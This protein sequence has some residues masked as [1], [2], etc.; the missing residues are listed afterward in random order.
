MRKVLI[1]AYYFPPSG[2]PGVQRV[3][4]YVQYLRDFGWEPVVLTVANG[5]FP[6]RDESLLAEIPE[7][8]E[9]IRT[10]IF[11][12]YDLYRKL[13]GKARG[14]AIDV[15]TMHKE[16]AKLP[17]KERI[18]ELI[19]ATIF[20]PDA[21]IGWY[22]TAV[23]AGLDAIEREGIEAIYSS[24][25]PYTCALIARGIKRRSGLPWI[26]GFRDPWTN[27]ITTPKRWALPAKIDRMLEHAVFREADEVEVAWVG[28]TRDARSKYPD[29]PEAKF[30]H[31]PNGFD[32][33]D[34]PT[35]DR[36]E[37][38]DDRFTVTYTGSMYGRR[39]PDAFLRAVESLVRRG[40]VERSRIRLRFIGRFGEEVMEMFRTSDL[41]DAIE[42]VGYMAH[43]ES[44]RQLLLADALLLVVDE[45]DESSEVVPGKVYEYVGSGRPVIA[46]APERSAI[47]DLIAE[48]RGGFVAHQ[49]NVAGIAD[50]FLRLYRAHVAGTAA[51]DPDTAAIARYERRSV[52]GELARLLDMVTQRARGV[53]T[54]AGAATDAVAR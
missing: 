22:S 36:S 38:S 8:V 18:A 53:S 51:L 14:V 2:G 28:I 12:P 24:S 1:V 39:N 11:E 4:K 33:R 54:P 45:C 5:N 31:L 26:A 13:T 46:V 7:G 21:R 32:S 47:A 35:V 48:T 50:A 20:I 29:L 19:R 27:F 15:N 41:G 16:G 6:A 49:S 25:P 3:L 42:V 30:H 17:L 43:T 44:I 10:E 40:E 52:T 9:V 34:I 23:K 37:R